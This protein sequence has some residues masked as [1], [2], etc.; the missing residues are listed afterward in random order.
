[1]TKWEACLWISA[2]AVAADSADDVL[3]WYFYEEWSADLRKLV[4]AR[5]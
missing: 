3:E 1:M 2:L 5:T 4:L